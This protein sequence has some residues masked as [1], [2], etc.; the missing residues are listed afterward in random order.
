[1]TAVVAVERKYAALHTKRIIIIK[2][3]TLIQPPTP[4]QTY[5]YIRL[6]TFKAKV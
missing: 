6:N 1:M 3:L 4:Q 2:D 5:F